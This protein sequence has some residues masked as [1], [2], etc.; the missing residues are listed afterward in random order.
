MP[1]R[2]VILRGQHIDTVRQAVHSLL[3]IVAKCRF[4][5]VVMRKAILKHLL[6]SS[7]I[8]CP[9]PEPLRSSGRHLPGCAMC[10]GPIFPR[11]WASAL[12]LTPATVLA[13][14][15]E[16]RRQPGARGSAGA[17]VALGVGEGQV[18]GH[19]WVGAGGPVGVPA[20]GNGAGVQM[21][22]HS[23]TCQPLHCLYAENPSHQL[24]TVGAQ[25]SRRSR[26]G[27]VCSASPAARA[28]T[29][30]GQSVLLR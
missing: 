10:V 12:E 2:C 17:R 27:V 11:A 15:T 18:V 21:A 8:Y 25:K 22:G 1:A 30:G 3:D 13:Q 5:R 14:W 20:R 16:Q 28:L 19:F 4:F 6:T 9:L 24:S 26:A 29:R 7:V 23:A